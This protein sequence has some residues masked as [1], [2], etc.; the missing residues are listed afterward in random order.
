LHLIF[1]INAG[2]LEQLDH[3]REQIA[4]VLAHERA[5]WRDAIAM[6]WAKGVVGR[7]YGAMADGPV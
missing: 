4:A 1:V 2:L 6:A 7:R 3:D 5:H